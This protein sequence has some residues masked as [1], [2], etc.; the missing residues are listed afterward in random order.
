VPDGGI[1]C[2]DCKKRRYGNM[3][4]L[5]F[6][7]ILG[8]LIL[9]A[10]AAYAGVYEFTPNAYNLDNLSHDRWYLWKF[11][12]AVPSGSEIVGATLTFTDITNWAYEP[13]NRLQ[14]HLINDP[15]LTNWSL[16]N[17]KTRTEYGVVQRTYWRTDND[18]STDNFATGANDKRIG[19]YR[20]LDGTYRESS[21][22]GDPEIT[23]DFANLANQPSTVTPLPSDVNLIDDLNLWA[24]DGN[25]AIGFDPDCHY[26][27]NG[28]KLTI[29]TRSVPT[30]TIPEPMSLM[31]GVMGLGSVAGLRRLRGK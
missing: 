30:Q 26:F 1:V 3:K 28:V 9:C 31:L 22:P 21:Q 18:N 11:G 2:A 8:C 15:N 14:L 10:A 5:V 7:L 23:F 19:I 16:S 6:S 25:W 29:T 20:D 17:S 13:N 24:A 27:N 12:W 4:R